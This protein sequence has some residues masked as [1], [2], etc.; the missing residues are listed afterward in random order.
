MSVEMLPALIPVLVAVI[1]LLLFWW[2]LRE[3]NRLERKRV[4]VSYL[5]KAL[6]KISQPVEEIMRLHD[7]ADD[8]AIKMVDSKMTP[9][10]RLKE[11]RS[12]H[13]AWESFVSEYRIVTFIPLTFA[14]QAGET[15]LA[16]SLACVNRA[17]WGL[18]HVLARIMERLMKDP[19]ELGSYKEKFAEIPEVKEAMGAQV[20][21]SSEMIKRIKKLYG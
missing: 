13:V 12:M 2:Q 3:Q 15:R 1:P 18:G 4:E 10:E 16:D 21:A 5:E 20:T 8:L 14:V 19:P 11:L 17:A 6:S 9:L 7:I